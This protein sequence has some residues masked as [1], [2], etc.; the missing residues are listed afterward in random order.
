[1]YEL[2]LFLDQTDGLYP[3]ERGLCGDV[4]GHS[5]LLLPTSGRRLRQLEPVPLLIRP[6]QPQSFPKCACH[7][8]PN[9]QR[10]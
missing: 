4:P 2:C 6:Q 8:F 5:G 7:P 10:S 3:H 1:M 9:Q